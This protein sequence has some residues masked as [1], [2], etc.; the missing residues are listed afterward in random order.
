MGEP[1]HSKK[2]NI[3]HTKSHDEVPLPTKESDATAQ[4]SEA[5]RMR[6]LLEE[7]RQTVKPLVKREAE[8][9]LVTDDVLSFRLNG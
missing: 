9:E 3:Q 4:E 8:A 2:P 1:R 6:E 7:A 5:S